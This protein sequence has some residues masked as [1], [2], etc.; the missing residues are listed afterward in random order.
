M[1][2]LVVKMWRDVP[3]CRLTECLGN[4]LARVLAAGADT[5]QD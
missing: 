4:L 2:P 3:T 1:R 5:V